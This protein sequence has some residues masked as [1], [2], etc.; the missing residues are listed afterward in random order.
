MGKYSF[1][2]INTSSALV[3]SEQDKD[4]VPDYIASP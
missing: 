2:E 1:E 3:I 4:F